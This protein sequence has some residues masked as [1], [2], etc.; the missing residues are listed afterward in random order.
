MYIRI[1]LSSANPAVHLW[2]ILEAPW[3]YVYTTVLHVLIFLI[4]L[5][6]NLFLAR[7]EN[8]TAILYISTC[9]DFRYID[10]SIVSA[11]K[12]LYPAPSSLNFI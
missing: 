6:R 5:P 9:R 8:Y 3:T 1:A 12:V 4:L 2:I 11:L 7:R 10:I